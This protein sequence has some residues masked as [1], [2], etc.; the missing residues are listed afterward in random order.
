MRNTD[1]CCIHTDKSLVLSS[2]LLT[3][4]T[5]DKV[6]GISICFCMYRSKTHDTIEDELCIAT[7]SK[8]CNCCCQQENVRI[9]TNIQIIC[10]ISLPLQFWFCLC[11]FF[12][13]MQQRKESNR[14][15]LRFLE[16]KSKTDP[17]LTKRQFVLVYKDIHH[18]VSLFK[19]RETKHHNICQPA[20]SSNEEENQ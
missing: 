1:T 13:R 3:V 16:D 4:Q 20:N 18:Y 9:M 7:R 14:N 6:N 10:L 19:T 15:S 11:Q 2:F 17:E 12:V 5:P 8:N